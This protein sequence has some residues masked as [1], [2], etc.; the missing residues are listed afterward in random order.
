M[1]E[2]DAIIVNIFDTAAAEPELAE[3]AEPL[4]ELWE[5]GDWEPDSIVATV[6]SLKS[7]DGEQP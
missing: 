1:A 7:A 2:P 3:L 4:R 6:E 5:A